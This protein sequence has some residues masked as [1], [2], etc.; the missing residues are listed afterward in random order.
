MGRGKIEIKKIENLNSRQVTFSKRRNGLLKKAKE[1]SVLCDAEVAVI[2]FSSTGKLYEFSSSSMEH[3]ISRYSTVSD[4]LERP[5]NPLA[6]ARGSQH[7][8][9]GEISR[10]KDEVS[11][12]RLSCLQM[13]GKQLDGL[14]FKEVH[15]LENQLTQGLLS[16]KDKKEQVLSE[17]LRNSRLQEQKVIE[18]N[19]TLRKQVEELKKN[20]SSK[21]KSLE[22]NVVE[23]GFSNN[24]DRS[25][26][27]RGADD[28]ADLSVTSLQLGLSCDVNGKRK[29]PKI[30]VTMNDSAGSQVA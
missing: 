3:T 8:E 16:I 24:E 18:E 7:L 12:L 30:E 25:A 27:K 29:S 5:Q 26:R 28:D 10:L 17:Q 2:V 11:K 19:E 21:S 4:S 15:Q 20:W 1:L 23:R 6:N 9:V 14:S 22:F 13:M